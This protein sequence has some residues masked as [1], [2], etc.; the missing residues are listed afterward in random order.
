MAQKVA[1]ARKMKSR[2]ETTSLGQNATVTA[3]PRISDKHLYTPTRDVLKF[4]PATW[5][6]PPIP[7]Q[8]LD[9]ALVSNHPAQ[10]VV[11]I[12][13]VATRT[14]IMRVVTRRASNVY[15][16]T[17]QFTCEATPEK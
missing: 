14:G 6:P 12:K 11:K 2:Q 1:T 7:W 13:V 10:E 3:K 16:S 4:R 9:K 8:G 15:F 5:D 17:A